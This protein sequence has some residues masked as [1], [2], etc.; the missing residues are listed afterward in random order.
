M[1][2]L[3]IA[4]VLLVAIE[5]HRRRQDRVA[6]DLI[7]GEIARNR[8]RYRKGM[9]RMDEQLRDRTAV[10]RR[11]REEALASFK[12]AQRCDRPRLHRAS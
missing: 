3:V 2:V 4:A 8:F 11:E 6:A 10:L 12:R 5:A 9:R 7:D 1:K